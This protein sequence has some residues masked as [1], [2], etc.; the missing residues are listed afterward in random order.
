MN[1]ISL[2]EYLELDPRAAIQVFDYR[3]YESSLKSK[4]NLNK[5]TFSFLLEGTKEVIT[6]HKAARI[7]NEKFLILKSGKCLMTE[8][9]STA[10][11]TYRSMLLFFSDEMLLD[12]LEKQARNSAHSQSAQSFFV[13]EYDP[14]IQQFVHSLTHIQYMEKELQQSLLKLKFEEIMTY[15]VRKEGIHFLTSILENHDNKTI[16]L[17]SVV[18]NNTLNKL[19]LQELSFLCNMSLSS[20][21]REFTRH[22]QL[23]PG[24]WF[25]EKRLEH[26]AFLLSTQKMR[27]T[28]LFE[29]AGYETLSNFVQAFKKKYGLTPKQFQRTKMDF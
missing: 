11:Q 17:I 27:P 4:I 14:Y 2:P 8:I 12:F 9:V 25:Q 22:Y 13:C 1:T 20:F 18:E 5:N 16:R 7:D 10:N 29:D 28:E 21:K 24:K 23:P 26:S 15:L 3:T 6:E 19:T